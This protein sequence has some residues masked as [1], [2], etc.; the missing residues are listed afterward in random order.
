[1]TEKTPQ[2]KMEDAKDDLEPEIEALW[3]EVR[4]RRDGRRPFP[5]GLKRKAFILLQLWAEASDLPFSLI[6]ALRTIY[7]VPDLP[8]HK[9][10]HSA[11]EACIQEEARA[12]L[13][14]ENAPLS[15]LLVKQLRHKYP[16][17]RRWRKDPEYRARVTQA[18]RGL[19]LTAKLRAA[20]MP[21]AIEKRRRD[22][23]RGASL[24]L[25]AL[26][27]ASKRPARRRK[28]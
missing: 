16:D 6:M 27:K 17:I 5:I 10:T 28:P 20:T 2:E 11:Y 26:D 15:V 24:R 22:Q 4:T 13:D 23:Q 9:G 3:T 14:P 7:K 18:R 21:D 1:M 8:G 12:P 19:A 25:S